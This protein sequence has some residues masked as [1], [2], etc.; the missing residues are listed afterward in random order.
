M[1]IEDTFKRLSAQNECGFIPF[2]TLGY[3]SID[4]TIDLVLAMEAGGAD[5]IELG[6]PFSDPLADGPTIQQASQTALANNMSV[7]KGLDIVE[8]LRQKGLKVPVV[9][10]GYLNPFLAFGLERLFERAKAVGV[11]GFI[12]PDLPA[13]EADQWLA[14][15]RKHSLDLIFFV[16]PSTSPTRAEAIVSKGTGFLYCLSRLGVTGAKASLPYDIKAYLD[17][18]RK[19]S[20]L[21][22]AVGFGI[23]KPEHVAELK[24]HA[25][26]IIV[27]S[28]LLELLKQCKP[29]ERVDELRGFIKRF[30][31]QTHRE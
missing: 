28:A 19:T 23:S 3:P 15:A 11:H 27:A 16:S 31:K 12:V 13:N 20:K 5:I 25:D 7:A 2:L 30:K 8:E 6:V 24:N 1:N 21:P 22:C 14:L 26:A 17:A 10:M 18:I 29:S 9:L 4:E